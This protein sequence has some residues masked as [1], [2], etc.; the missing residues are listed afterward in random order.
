MSKILKILVDQIMEVECT[1][2]KTGFS[3]V[4]GIRSM[5]VFAFTI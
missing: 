1:D 5:A 3:A 4:H 2:K